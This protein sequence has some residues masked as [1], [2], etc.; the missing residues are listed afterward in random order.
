MLYAESE[1]ELDDLYDSLVSDEVVLTYPNFCKYVE[2]VCEDRQSWA[3][4][5]R[6][7]LP[8]RGNNTNN[9]CEA[10]FLILKDEILNRQKEVNVVGL[11]DKFTTEFDQHYRNKLL[12]VASGK[13]DGIYSRRFKGLEKKKT[14]G[15]GFKK[16]TAEQEKLTLENV[17]KVTDNIFIVPSLSK[18]GQTYLVDMSSG[19]CQCKTGMNGSPCKHQY[20]LWVNKVSDAVNFLP[21]FSKEQRQMYAEVAI[22]NGY[23]KYSIISKCWV[24]KYREGGWGLENFVKNFSFSSTYPP[25]PP[26]NDWSLI[27]W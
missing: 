26:L 4:C 14:E 17:E 15:A 6:V 21:I 2:A 11:M 8:L 3:L 18:E 23:L 27:S 19:F 12:S 9:Y 16:L 7:N 22:G 24:I 25:P 5:Y 1:E 20:T 10:Q 13:Y